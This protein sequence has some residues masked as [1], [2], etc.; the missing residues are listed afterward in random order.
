M[1]ELRDRMV[2]DMRVRDFSL[3]TQEAYLAAVTGLAAY[4]HK[5]PDLLSDDQIQRY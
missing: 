4:Y 1:G 3:R 5:A 2:Q